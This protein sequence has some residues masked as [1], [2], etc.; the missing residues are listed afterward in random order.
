MQSAS[1]QESTLGR[2]TLVQAELPDLKAKAWNTRVMVSWLATVAGRSTV[3]HRQEPSAR[4][5]CRGACIGHLAAWYDTLERAG[6]FLSDA[7]RIAACDAG[8]SFLLCYVQLARYASAAGQALWPLKPKHHKMD[9]MVRRLLLDSYNPRF[10][11]CYRDEDWCGHMKNLAKNT[12]ARRG[13]E[14]TLQRYKLLLS[15]LWHD[16]RHDVEAQGF[17]ARAAT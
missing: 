13:H 9:H 11:D 2:K 17:L 12:H 16:L 10:S 8:R 3:R 15:V 5:N 7:E 1:F 4:D 6:R 14:R